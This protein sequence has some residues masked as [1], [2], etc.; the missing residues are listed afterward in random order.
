MHARKCV[1]YKILR[2]LHTFAHTRALIHIF[3]HSHALMHTRTH[4]CTL[5]HAHVHAQQRCRPFRVRHSAGQ[6]RQVTAPYGTGRARGKVYTTHIRVN[7]FSFCLPFSMCLFLSRSLHLSL[8]LYI[9]ISHFHTQKEEAQ[10]YFEKSLAI[11]EQVL[12][13]MHISI[14]FIR[15]FVCMCICRCGEEEKL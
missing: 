3:I 4:S 14:C 10:E 2:H 15:K 1:S 11:K 6:Q 8:S 9:S 13:Q 5:A 7:I 12:G